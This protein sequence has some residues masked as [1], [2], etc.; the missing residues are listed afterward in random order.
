VSRAE[1]PVR[2][3]GVV[4]A[5]GFARRAGGTDKLLVPLRGRPL[6][7]HVIR[8]AGGAGLSPVVVVTRPDAPAL[9][10][11][12][13]DLPVEVV[14]N[15]RPGD[16]L[17]TSLRCGLAALPAGIAGAAILLG[18]MPWVRSSTIRTLTDTLDD[19]DGRS[20][21]VP[22]HRGQRGNP[23]VWSAR[24]FAAMASL[25]GD[26]GARRLLQQFAEQVCEVPV[27]DAGVLRDIDTADEIER[28]NGASS[29]PP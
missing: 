20:I 26:E 5:A 4:L 8:A 25:A 17:S 2:V 23:V 12:L 28:L 10:G 9:R 22:V 21:C 7:E 18:D 11:A 27:D 24:F 14:E 3:A 29:C 13:T 19:D 16:G 6:I 1:R 15:P